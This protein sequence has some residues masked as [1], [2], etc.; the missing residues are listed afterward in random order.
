MR[1]NRK[2]RGFAVTPLKKMVVWFNIT[3]ILQLRRKA[4][5]NQLMQFFIKNTE[6]Y[7]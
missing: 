5:I 4:I 2:T 3:K 1:Y 7:F 6:G